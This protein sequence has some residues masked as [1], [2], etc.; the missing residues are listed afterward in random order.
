MKGLEK[1]SKFA[2]ARLNRGLPS[3]LI[4]F[5]TNVCNLKC[6]HCFYWKQ[7]NTSVEDLTL[8]EI[9][10]ISRHLAWLN[11][12]SLSGGEPFLRKDLAGILEIFYRNN[13]LQFS[14]IPT[15]GYFLDPTLTVLKKLRSLCPKLK[16]TI[17]VSLDGTR[18]IHDRIR[19]VKGSF[20]KAFKSLEALRE[21]QRN[22]AGLEVVTNTVVNNK[23][24]ED[25]LELYRLLKERFRGM[26]VGLSLYRGGGFGDNLLPPTEP[27]WQQIIEILRQQERGEMK[28]SPALGNWYHRMRTDYL[29]YVNLRALHGEVSP[30]NCSA[31]D[32]IGVLD[33]NGDVKVCEN[34]PPFGNVRDYNYDF[35]ALWGSEKAQV[36]RRL[37]R[38]CFCNHPCF[39]QASTSYYLSNQATILLYNLH[40][41]LSLE[42]K[43][44]SRKKHFLELQQA[45]SG[46]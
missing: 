40:K 22:H 34:Y 45:Q 5:V 38:E 3:S 9:E 43:K 11:N 32:I 18:E 19:G 13:S 31:G 20:D 16:L 6:E 33:H 46:S 39:L 12:L 44:S 17:Q 1:I 24:F 27:Q 36:M 4:Y 7:L 28:R 41:N 10:K 26:H 23:N 25:V 14:L 37:V 35:E 29:D 15:N 8:E 2:R 30:W 21:Y 42:F